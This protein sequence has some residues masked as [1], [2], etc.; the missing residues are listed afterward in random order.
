MVQ[1]SETKN[2]RVKFIIELYKELKKN[3]MD[4]ITNDKLCMM[5]NDIRKFMKN[6]E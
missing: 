6:K 2:M 3:Q 4:E 5:I 1:Y